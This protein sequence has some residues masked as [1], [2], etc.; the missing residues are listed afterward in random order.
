M[1]GES[2]Q[3]SAGACEQ[4]L[5][6]VYGELSPDAARAFEQHLAG[7]ARCQTEAQSFGRVRAVTQEYRDAWLAN[8]AARVMATL[9]PTGRW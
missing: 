3:N 5:D 4:L 7:C 1:N 6:Y 9:L 8:D 2:E